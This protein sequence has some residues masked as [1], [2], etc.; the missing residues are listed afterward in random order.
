VSP[1]S[2]TLDFQPGSDTRIFSLVTNQV[3]VIPRPLAVALILWGIGALLAGCD[4]PSSP[5]VVPAPQKDRPPTVASADFKQRQADFL[6]RIRAA[7]PDHRTVDRAM[8]NQQNELGLMLDRTV[9]MDR[10]PDLM[11]SILTQMA[12][13]FPGHDLTVLTYMPSNPPRKIGT[14]HFNAHTRDMTYTPAQ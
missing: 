1:F 5:P 10:V 12:R 13:E 7:D 9:E 3:I 4:Q 11:R 8:L 6:N 2:P 14:A